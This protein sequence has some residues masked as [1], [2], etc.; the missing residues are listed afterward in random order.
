MQVSTNRKVVCP[1]ESVSLSSIILNNGLRLGTVYVRFLIA[2]SYQLHQPIFDS[3]RDL[4]KVKRNA[5]RLEDLKIREKREVTCRW[6]VPSGSSQMHF[7]VKVEVWNPHFLF[8]G[9][10]PA[11]FYESDWIGG[12]LV[13]PTKKTVGSSK[14]FISYSW[15]SDKHRKWVND[16]DE[17]L[18][19]HGIETI[20]DKKDV[21][22]GE[23]TTHFMEKA[24]SRA[25]TIV[26]VCSKNYTQKANNRKPGG[27]GYETILTS[28]E[29][30]QRQPEARAR[31]IPV[32]RGNDLPERQKLPRY[33]GSA[34][35]V[36][37]SGS[38]W[39]AGPMTNLVAAIE[40]HG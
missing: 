5:M 30:L 27:V 40:S 16:F 33:L 4:R 25:R 28:H 8:N 24:I 32:I 29:Y 3:D 15:D 31:I 20:F 22:P 11:C 14:T 37:M 18:T 39:R 35:Y 21:L 12:F 17:E 36:D 19:K 7:D 34:F 9:P 2:N 10:R 38:D 23:E 26:I 6:K 1:G 13:T